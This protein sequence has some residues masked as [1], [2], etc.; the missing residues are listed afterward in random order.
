MFGFQ[1]WL[2]TSQPLAI[3]EDARQQSI[4]KAKSAVSAPAE[5]QVGVPHPV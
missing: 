3:G 1:I 4:R 5:I 2:T